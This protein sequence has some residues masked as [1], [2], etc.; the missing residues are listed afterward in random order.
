[1]VADYGEEKKPV[2]PEDPDIA[3]LKKEI[4]AHSKNIEKFDA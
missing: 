4:E 3:R 2:E 1:M